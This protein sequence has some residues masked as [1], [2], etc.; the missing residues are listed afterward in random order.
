[1]NILI[2]GGTGFIGRALLPHFERQGAHLVVLTRQALDDTP[3]RR[4]INNLDEIAASDSIHA[5]I[6]LAGESMAGQRWSP[7]YKQKLVD[8]RLDITAALVTLM[9]RLDR[10]PMVMLSA[11]AI[12]FYGRRSDEILAE[13]DAG[14]PGFSQDLCSRWEAVALGARRLGVRVCLLRLGVVLDAGGG[15]LQQMSL[16]FK[17][18]VGNWMGA[19]KQW[20]SWVHRQDVVEAIDL[21]LSRQDLQGP[22]N[23]TAPHPVTSRGFCEVMARER[24]VLFSVPMPAPVLRMMVGEMADELLLN[25]QRVVPRAL[26]AAGYSFVFPHLQDALSASH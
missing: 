23:I 4:H 15:A 12:G 26:Q 3:T 18:G 9:E 20:L 11:S 14:I 16:P 7:D 2:T 17:F 10:V 22:F 5:V 13:K 19:G 24:R 1:M 21:L 25:G 8:S 6:N